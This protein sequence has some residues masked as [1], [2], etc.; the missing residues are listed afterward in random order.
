MGASLDSRNDRHTYVGK[1][2]QSL[3]AFVMN[4]APNT[5]IGDIAER[6]PF[7]VSNE[8]SARARQDYDLV[9]P[10]LRNPVE[11]IDKFRVGWRRHNERPAV[12]VELG[13]QYALGVARQLE[14]TIGGEVVILKCLHGIF[15]S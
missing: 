10:V 12:A 6:G 14:I 1:V 8:L 13:D 11:G 2:F 15:L 3:N 9:R 5:R 4:L 7:D